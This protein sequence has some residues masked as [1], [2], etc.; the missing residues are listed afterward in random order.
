[1][2]FGQARAAGAAGFHSFSKPLDSRDLA[3][4]KAGGANDDKKYSV[5]F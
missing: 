4:A 3:P 1:M 5:N 2:N